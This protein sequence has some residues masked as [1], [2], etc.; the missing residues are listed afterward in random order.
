VCGHT[1][2]ETQKEKIHDSRGSAWQKLETQALMKGVSNTEGFLWGGA[3][4]G[5]VFRKH[6]VGAPC[7]VRTFEF[8]ENVFDLQS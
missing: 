8:T 2:T 7:L 1:S 3:G 5:G 4:W 6:F